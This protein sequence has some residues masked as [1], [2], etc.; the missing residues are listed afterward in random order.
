M[1]VPEGQRFI[2]LTEL[3]RDKGAEV[4]FFD[5]KEPIGQTLKQQAEQGKR[6]AQGAD[7]R[8]QVEELEKSSGVRYGIGE[9]F[10][11]DRRY[12]VLK[13]GEPTGV[14]FVETTGKWSAEASSTALNEDNRDLVWTEAKSLEEALDWVERANN[15]DE[16]V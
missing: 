9:T 8:R 6:I 3:G 2:D 14:F 1:S 5:D 12:E 16:A 7:A 15:L 10:G 13:E 4:D 11:D